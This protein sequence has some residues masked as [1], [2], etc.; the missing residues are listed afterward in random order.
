MKRF[1]PITGK[2][3]FILILTLVTYGITYSQ[4]G[5]ST[6]IA[7]KNKK[8]SEKV[9]DSCYSKSINDSCMHWKGNKGFCKDGK[10]PCRMRDKFID[11]DSDGI[12]DERCMGLGLGNKHR[13]G[14]CCEKKK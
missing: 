6:G 10:Q 13:K 2:V 9:T 8:K 1:F 12:N 3:L 11:N 7:K 5:K 14:K 4:S